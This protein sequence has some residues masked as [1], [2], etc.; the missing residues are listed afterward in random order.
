MKKLLDSKIANPVL[1]IVFIFL[2]FYFGYLYRE[3]EFVSYLHQFRP[4]RQELPEFSYVSPLVGTDSPSALTVGLFSDTKDKLDNL[5]KK[6][7][8]QGLISSGI[9]YRDLN[10]AVWFGLNEDEKFVPASLLK[11]T[12][13]LA[14]YKQNES[15]PS[16][17]DKRFVYTQE[18]ADETR[19]R[20]NAEVETSLVLGN[21][22]SVR[23]LI[24]IMLIESDNGARDMLSHVTDQRYLNKVYAYLGIE[25]PSANNDFKISTAD[26]ALFFRMLYSSTFINEEHSQDL[27]SILTKTVFPYGIRQ[28]IPSPIG[29][30]HKWGVYNFPKSAN[31]V[32]LQELHDCGIVYD[33]ETPFLIC[34]MTEG[35]DQQVL[36]NFMAEVAKII[37]EDVVGSRG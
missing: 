8:K 35:D 32:Q 2:A 29:F 10:S 37:Y 11:M 3:R 28:S 13:A 15:D 16:F 26:Y 14:A 12:F 7:K 34:I 17:L 30:A 36:V 19:R 6:Y 27:L 1:M 31:G 20:N 18:I 22:Y 23:E 21:S 4:I 9:Y 25:E 33:P 5:I 24:Q